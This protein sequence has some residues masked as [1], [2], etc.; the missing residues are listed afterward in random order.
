[1]E[2]ENTSIHDFELQ[3][4]CDYF[5]NFERQGPGSSEMTVK[6]LSFID[7]LTEKSKIA[8]I[9]C[10]TGGQTMVLAQNT[11][12]TITG[13]D[14]F[15]GFI[16]IFNK[17]A[18]K[19][20]LQNRVTG[21]VASMDALP[22]A[23]EEYDL[24][25]SEGAIYNIGFERGLKEWSK[26]LKKG[27]YIAVTDASWFTGEG[28]GSAERPCEIENFWVQEYPGINT[29]SN[30]IKAMQRAGY[31]PVAIFT[32]P[33]HCWTENYHAPQ[34]PVQEEFLEKY[35]G[36]KKVEDFIAYA[37]HEAEMYKKYKDHYGYVF[38]IGRKA[39]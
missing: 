18:A 6:A 39:T 21:I 30:N 28:E 27:G 22:S 19:L 7:N 23:D 15:P 12:G 5:S 20:N 8:D 38:Y 34:I 16:S 3:L 2:T 14:F 11:T 9:G 37:R 33:E 1:M 35:K 24:I 29:I 26:Y 13:I 10:G 17:N 31:M 36:N 25:W 32:L 4:I